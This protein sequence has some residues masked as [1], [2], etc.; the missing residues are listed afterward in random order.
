MLNPTSLPSFHIVVYL[1]P[2]STLAP[3]Q[4]TV[5]MP[6]LDF[7]LDRMAVRFGNLQNI[8]E[9]GSLDVT[10]GRGG[11]DAVYV[12][13]DKVD[14]RTGENSVRGRWNITE[15]II[16]NNT[17]G[18]I[19]AEII[20]HDSEEASSGENDTLDSPFSKRR[21]GQL[22]DEAQHQAR[23]WYS[24]N[25]ATSVAVADARPV[26]SQSG[27]NVDTSAYDEA[28]SH[29]GQPDSGS[30]SSVY[31]ENGVTRRRT[32]STWFM[33]AEGILA[34]A[35]L[36]QP[37]TVSLS[38][39]FIN[40]AGDSSISLHPNYIGPFV[41]KNTWGQVRVPPPMPI[42]SL[43]PMHQGRTRTVSFGDIDIPNAGIYVDNGLNETVL[44]GSAVAFSGAVYWKGADNSS[45]PTRANGLMSGGMG[46]NTLSP[47]EVQRLE[48]A[49][50]EVLVMNSWGN[51]DLTF[52]GR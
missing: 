20:L 7:V 9:F 26:S 4:S 12:S 2:S 19:I 11:V 3:S 13:A 39:L 15:S 29:N 45:V 52:D 18:S 1:P 28:V 35:Y 48:E 6:N 30:G 44:E 14:V 36:H 31:S 10:S 43:D 8:V 46:N 22:G 47:K 42:T 51:V 33:T 5:S 38:G 49:D 16:V 41:T 32:V 24:S 17:E 25:P 27:N 37:S 50:G 21:R 40:G 23:N 34:V